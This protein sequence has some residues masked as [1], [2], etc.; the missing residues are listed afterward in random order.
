M[1][2]VKRC[3]YPAL[4]LYN[5]DC[6]DV[7]NTKNSQWCYRTN[8]VNKMFSCAFSFES[9]DCINSR[10][11]FDC[12]NCENCFGATNKRNAKYIFFNQQLSKEEYQERLLKID[13]SSQKVLEENQTKFQ[14]LME[15]AVWPEN[16]NVGSSESTG[17][18]IEESTRCRNGYWQGKSTDMFW[19]WISEEQ[20]DSA[21]STYAGWGS[22]AYYTCDVVGGSQLRFCF[23]CWRCINMEYCLD[24]YDCE[25][26]FG[27]VGLRKNSF[28]IFNK[29]YSEDEYWKK[30]DELK[31][32]ML[33][34]GEYGEYFPATFSENG[35]EYSM[36]EAF[37]GYSNEELV[38]FQAVLFDP[39]RGD[40]N[41]SSEA[42][43]ELLLLDVNTIPDCL[44]E[45][46][47]EIFVG[48]PI[49][50]LIL[51]RPFS[52]TRGEMAFYRKQNY[53]FPRE[54]FLRRLKALIRTSNSPEPENRLCA[55]C[56]R[57]II[58]YRNSSFVV[59]RVFCKNCYLKFLEENN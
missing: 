17:E 13:L 55:N 32:A 3:F 51:S 33:D 36:G 2:G 49:L 20:H 28:C 31:C 53:P 8:R 43:T 22:D 24:C 18:Y 57:E 37:F 42:T 54:H 58:S 47:E 35:L 34:C 50:D 41:S 10:F 46:N 21:F 38:Q 5:E 12:R 30:V 23:R 11:L 27:C 29:Q 19:C 44:V 25:N 56:S 15:M 40:V 7:T 45:I 39:K 14:S 4:S 26:C 59:R 48:K 9:R 16:F 1:C 6:V 52:V